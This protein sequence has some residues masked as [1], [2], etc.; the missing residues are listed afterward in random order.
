MAIMRALVVKP[1]DKLVT[2]QEIPVPEPGPSEV[3]V[4]VGAVALNRVDW[5]YTTNPVAAQ[6]YRVVGSD[7]AGVITKV[8]EDVEKLDDPRAKVGTRVAS[9]VQGACSVN[10][11]PGAFAQ[12]VCTEWDLTWHIPNTMSLEEAAGISMCGLTAAQGVF[13]RLQLPCPFAE[14]EG[15]DRL[16]L[17]PEE[18]VNFLIYG[19]TA[20]LGLFA[21]QLVRLSEQFSGR[22]I[23]LIGVAS[24]SKHDL[25]REKPYSFDVLIDYHDADWPE[26]VRKLTESSRGVDY[27]VD[28][29]SVSPTVE[30]VGSTLASD[31][32]FAV[33]RSP[34]LGNFDINKLTIKPLIGAVWEGLGVEIGYQGASIPMNPEAREFTTKFFEFLGSEALSGKAKLESNPVRHMSGG[35]DKIE[36]GLALVSP[37]KVPGV[38]SVSAEKVVYTIE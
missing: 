8:G 15:F 25:L 2:V 38:R 14:T 10:D 3:L 7:F 17:K 27:A 24:A 35:L 21:T 30:Q 23:C 31:G 29:V 26:Q 22:K 6:D 32:R 34:A 9:F 18:R 13:S 12:Y 33:Y 20:S 5:L 11:R 19:V 16:G 4:R 28:A 1:K 37:N 36:E